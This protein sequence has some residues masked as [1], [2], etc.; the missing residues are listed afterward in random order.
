MENNGKIK[1]SGA[2]LGQDNNRKIHLLYDHAGLSNSVLKL[3]VLYAVYIY[4]HIFSYI[5]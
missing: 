1:Y 2:D 3:L 4:Y 5:N